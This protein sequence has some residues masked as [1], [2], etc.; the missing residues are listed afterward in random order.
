LNRKTGAFQ[1]ELPGNFPVEPEKTPIP[2][3]NV[4]FRF[5]FHI[6]AA[7]E[8][9]KAKQP[10]GDHFFAIFKETIMWN[11]SNKNEE[12]LQNIVKAVNSNMESG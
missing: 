10:T 6:L 7:A 3:D 1:P 2:A 9:A 4:L 5:G 11:H 8:S 12:T